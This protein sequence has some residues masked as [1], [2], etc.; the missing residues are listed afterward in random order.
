M[1]REVGALREAVEALAAKAP[2]ES[3]QP[4]AE[5]ALA[6]PLPLVRMA[7]DEPP[8]RAAPPTSPAAGAAASKKRGRVKALGERVDRLERQVAKL[9]RG[10]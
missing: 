3:A 6:E 2:E 8:D 9:K 7:I 1:V 5:P 10:R 4:R